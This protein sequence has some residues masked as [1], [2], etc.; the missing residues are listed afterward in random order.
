MELVTEEFFKNFLLVQSCQEPC[1]Q[2]S[3]PSQPPTVTLW[4]YRAGKNREDYQGLPHSQTDKHTLRGR[5]PPSPPGWLVP[6]KLGSLPSLP[7]QGLAL[8]MMHWGTP[9]GTPPL[10]EPVAKA[11]GCCLFL[12]GQHCDPLTH[13][14]LNPEMFERTNS[15]F[16][17]LGA[18]GL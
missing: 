7:S 12:R 2:M 14:Q 13:S 3:S 4:N 5:V 18:V 1:I 16:P 10:L 9:E 17:M 8:P 11:Q 15:L 6:N